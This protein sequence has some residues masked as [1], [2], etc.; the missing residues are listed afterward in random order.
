MKVN[1]YRIE[2]GKS[3]A[4]LRDIPMWS[5]QWWWQWVILNIVGWSL[6][7]NC[8]IATVAQALR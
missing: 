1:G 7:P 2:L 4:A 6:L 5:S 8:T 3:S